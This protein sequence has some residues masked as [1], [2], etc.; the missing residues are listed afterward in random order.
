[1]L[2][3]IGPRKHDF[4]CVT[5]VSQAPPRLW[6]GAERLPLAAGSKWRLS[7]DVRRVSWDLA[8]RYALE[9][10]EALCHVKGTASD[11]HQ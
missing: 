6:E 10:I 8:D 3:V 7:A 9:P 11:T 2:P 1:M 5:G 4:S